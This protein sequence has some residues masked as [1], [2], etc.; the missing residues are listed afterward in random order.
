MTALTDDI[1]Q[2]KNLASTPEC[3]ATLLAVL[4]D[5]PAECSVHVQQ[6]GSQLQ[7]GLPEIIFSGWIAV[8]LC[9][10]SMQHGH[11]K[12][13]AVVFQRRVVRRTPTEKPNG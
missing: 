7:A 8:N 1:F 10:F 11:P 12:V 9:S 13:P 3:S 6:S 2:N 4:H 5:L